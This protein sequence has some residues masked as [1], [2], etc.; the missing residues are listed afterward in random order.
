MLLEAALLTVKREVPFLGETLE[1]LR[2]TRFFERKDRLPLRMIAG[3][4]GTQHFQDCPRFEGA[5]S[6]HGLEE[7]EA[8]FMGYGTLGPRRRC[9][10][11]HYRAM[12]QL[13]LLD[14]AWD[15][16]LIFEDDLAFA[17][18]WLEYLDSVL[19][20]VR[21]VYGDRWIVTLYRVK[22]PDQTPVSKAVRAGRQWLL[23]P[24]KEEFWG[25]QAIAYSRKVLPRIQ[26]N[27]WDHAI[28]RFDY[29]VDIAIGYAAD[30]EGIPILA[31]APSLVQHMGYRSTGQSKWFHRAECF[32]ESVVGDSWKARE[33]D[34]GGCWLPQWGEP[35]GKEPWSR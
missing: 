16:A 14:T 2:R 26:Q 17:D 21:H 12:H 34:P 31:T 20:E 30:S 4:P 22:H 32:Y 19:E 27:L 10:F 15:A 18:G 11:G 9:A 6:F 23:I 25:T 1:S 24:R 3:A 28:R 33:P 35:P 7:A 13:S 29:P 8:K 5:I